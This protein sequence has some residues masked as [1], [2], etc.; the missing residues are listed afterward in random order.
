MFTDPKRDNET[1]YND[2]PPAKSSLTWRIGVALI[3]VAVLGALLF[4]SAGAHAADANVCW[5][6]TPT[7]WQ[8]GSTLSASEIK[9]FELMVTPNASTT[10][11]KAGEI[12]GAAAKCIKMSNIAVGPSCFTV[13]VVANNGEKSSPSTPL[14]C[15]T[16]KG[17]P[18][19][20][21]GVTVTL[22]I[23]ISTTPTGGS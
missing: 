15:I 23:T 14:A 21:T 11:V 9:G 17:A 22:E 3:I 12:F 18:Q 8:D 16:H 7:K 5:T 20:V 1:S 13:L 19:G 2:L 6:G 4:H 10:P